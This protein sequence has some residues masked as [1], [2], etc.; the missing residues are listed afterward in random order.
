MS[1]LELLKRIDEEL[2]IGEKLV[3]QQVAIE[4][5][6]KRSINKVSN[7]DPYIDQVLQNAQDRLDYMILC[8]KRLRL[9]IQIESLQEKLNQ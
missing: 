5:D 2:E 1:L 6:R 3:K 7:A 9:D 8:N 4:N